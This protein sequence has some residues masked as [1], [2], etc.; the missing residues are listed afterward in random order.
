MS[1]S[2]NLLLDTA[3]D[4]CGKLADASFADG[5]SRI[6]EAGLPSLLVP[7]AR[8]GFGGDWGDALAVLRVAGARALPL[9]LGE[10]I[11][12]AS[13]VAGAGLDIPGHPMSI[14]AR[15]TGRLEGERRF[16]GTVSAVPWGRDVG[17]VVVIVNGRAVLF[18]TTAAR[19][20]QGVNPAGEPRDRLTFESAAVASG[21]CDA[22]LLSLGAFIRVGQCDG[23]LSAALALAIEYAN[24]RVQFGKPLAKL[25]AVQQSLAIAASEAA[26]VSAAADGLADALD[27]GDANFET[28][29]AKLRMNIAIAAMTSIT[30]QVHGAI[31]FTHEYPLH[32][33]TRRMMGWRSEYGNDRYWSDR[34]GSVALR[35][36]GAGLW[37]EISR[38]TDPLLTER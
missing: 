10:C 9:P 36:G 23:A 2:R 14:G 13:V 19:I 27:R 7:E 22:D 1:E 20:E 31:G 29:A 11:V 35:L 33:L 26:A 30:H 24:T 8:D 18:P 12:A 3:E 15:V 38:R 37:A 4:V 17:T 34:L 21:A 28:A 5:W 32:R 16:S 6:V 25:Q